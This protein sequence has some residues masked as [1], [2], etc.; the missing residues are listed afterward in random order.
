MCKK[1]P[2][3]H[4]GMLYLI[5]DTEE[6]LDK[7]TEEGFTTTLVTYNGCPIE[8]EDIADVTTDILIMRT[9]GPK[10][11]M[12]TPPILDG[13]L[14]RYCMD[15][16]LLIDLGREFSKDTKVVVVDN[17]SKHKHHLG[18]FVSP[19]FAYSAQETIMYK[20]GKITLLRSK[21]RK[22]GVILDNIIY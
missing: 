2:I 12:C 5:T 20:D 11:N 6:Y 10:Y 15:I 19:E 22:S 3:M 17:Y 9:N 16:E 1:K 14:Y 13:S 21:L 8:I 4:K 7:I 18:E